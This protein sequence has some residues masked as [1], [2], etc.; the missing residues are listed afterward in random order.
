MASS[1]TQV[2]GEYKKS[3]DIKDE[4]NKGSFDAYHLRFV[5]CKWK[6]VNAFLGL[7]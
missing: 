2:V 3:M 1:S 5:D 4:I 7:N 6:V